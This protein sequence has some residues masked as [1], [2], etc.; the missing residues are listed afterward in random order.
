MENS[1]NLSTSQAL[2]L[3]QEQLAQQARLFDTVLS[4]IVDF[5]YTFDRAGRFTYVNQALLDL[6][7]IPLEEALG[8][9]FFELN[10]PA[11]LAAALQKQI[12]IVYE[13]GQTL[14]DETPYTSAAGT[15]GYYEYIFVPV[16][17]KQGQVETVVGSTRDITERHQEKAEREILLKTL[18]VER[19]RLANLFLQ[20]PAFIAVL[21]GAEHTFEL[22]NAPYYQM[23]GNRELIGKKVRD[24]L[25]E[26]EGQGFFEILD[27][28]YRSGK[29]FVGKNMAIAFQENPD[30]PC[31]EH[32]LDFVYQPLIEADGTVSGIVAHG[33][34]LTDHKLAQQALEERTREIENLNERLQ[35]SMTETHH[36]V[37]NNLQVIS[38][39]IEMQAF[40]YETVHQVPLEKFLQLK[41]HISTLSLVHDLLTKSVKENEDAQ[42]V[43]AKVILERLL[44]MLQQTA[45]KGKLHYAIDDAVLTSQQ[46]IAL[47]L[48]LNELVSNALKHGNTAAE[49]TLSVR[50]HEAV[51]TISDDGAG[52]PDGFDV[53]RAANTGLEVV[54]SLVR[55]DLKGTLRFSNREQGGGQVE[56]TF[57]LPQENE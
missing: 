50:D 44:P 10:Y 46:C 53:R 13:N 23:V 47:S 1:E 52:F 42:R 16:F 18:E 20:T 34:D 57:S 2:S 22:V 24:A 27:E 26:I 25:P 12:E 31:N 5:V 32:F 8:K 9:N 45:G 49:V 21:R 43:S 39:L 7:Q 35:R 3:A 36:R 48:I 33:V 37:K 6:W 55:S 15:T 38:S 41:T 4:S 40:D 28:V 30:T 54:T 11:K 29:P 56:V 14:R 19:K 17:D 51:L